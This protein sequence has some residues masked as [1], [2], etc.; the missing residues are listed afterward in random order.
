ML[1]FVASRY[2]RCPSDRILVVYGKVGGE[3]KGRA[4]GRAEGGHADLTGAD[5]RFDA[6]VWLTDMAGRV[7]VRNHAVP[8]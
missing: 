1:I 5:D 6:E 4:S 7:R 2:R 8:R 3:E